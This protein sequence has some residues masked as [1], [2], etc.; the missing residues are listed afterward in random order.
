[1]NDSRKISVVSPTFNRY[2]FTIRSFEQV[3]ADERISECVLVD[4]ASTDDSYN[5][6][7]N[8]FRD[9]IKVKLYQNSFNL[10]CAFNKRRAMELATGEYAAII[11]SD[12]VI[13]QKFI[14]VIFDYDWREDMLFQ[15]EYLMPN[16]DFRPYGGM[17][18]TKNNIGNTLEQHPF[19]QTLLNAHNCFC[20]RKSY[21]DVIQ[22]Q[23]DAI[24][25]DSILFS[26]KWLESGRSIFVTPGLHYMHT[27]HKDSHYQNFNHLTPKG[28]HEQ[29]LKQLKELQ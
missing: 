15:P 24:T 4:D 29:I 28:L 8:F 27:V 10:G 26:F 23:P 11:D 6:L 22:G 7:C 1:M 18:L 9:N 19:L 3:L 14:D 21:L 13:D 12:N 2:E 17:L 25:S 20:N 5:K 16:F